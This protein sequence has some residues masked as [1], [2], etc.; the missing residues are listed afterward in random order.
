MKLFFFT[1]FGLNL[2]LTSMQEKDDSINDAIN[3]AMIKIQ[4]EIINENNN[5]NNVFTL[6]VSLQSIQFHAY[7]D[8]EIRKLASVQVTNCS[9]Y[10]RRFPKSNGLNDIRMGINDPNLKCPTC[11]KANDCS[12]H[13][14]FIELE[15]PI[16]RIGFINLTLQL[17][18]CVCWG[19]SKPKFYDSSNPYTDF[20]FPDFIKKN[21]LDIKS[22]LV[23]HKDPKDILKMVS[24]FCKKKNVCPWHTNDIKTKEEKEQAE[25][26]NLINESCGLPQCTYTKINK[27]FIKRTFFEKAVSFLEK[28]EQ[29]ILENE[30]VFP[31]DIRNIFC[32]IHEEVFQKLGFSP[33]ISHPKNFIG[34]TLLVPPPNIRPANISGDTQQRCENDITMLYQNVIR[35]NEELKCALELFHKEHNIIEDVFDSNNY[36]K[37]ILELWDKLQILSAAIINQN[38]KNVETYNGKPA[39]FQNNAPK[40]ILKDIKSRL[41]GK[42]GRLRANLSGKRVDHAARTVIGPDSTHDIFELGVPS[43]IMNTLTF[44]E[45]VCSLNIENLRNRINIG[46]HDDD[47]ALCIITKKGGILYLQSMNKESKKKISENL[48]IGDV[49]E[50]HLK[51]GDWVV[52]NRQPTLHKAS[53]MAFQCYRVEGYQFKLSLACTRA[54]NADFDGDEMNLHALQDYGAI[55]EAMSLMSVPHQIVTPQNNQVLISLVQDGL[56]GVFKLSDE[57][58]FMTKETAMQLSLQIHYDPNSEDY[59]FPPMTSK[60]GPTPFLYSQGTTNFQEKISGKQ[61]LSFLFP[62]NFTFLYEDIYISEGIFFKGQLKKKSVGTGGVLIKSMWQ[63]YG[64]WATAKFISDLQ[65]VAVTWLTYETE[66][67]SIKDCLISEEES[68]KR[69]QIITEA[70]GKTKDIQDLKNGILYDVREFLQTKILQDTRREIGSMILEKMNERQGAISTLVHCGSKGNEMNISQISGIVGQQS[71]GG[72]RIPFTLSPI[73]P[74]TLACFSPND[75]SPFSRGFICNSY[76]KGLTPSEFFYHQQAGREGVVATAVQ[77]ADAGYNQRRMIKNQESEVVAYDFTVRGS[78]NNILQYKYG[79]DGLD[80]S[81]LIRINLEKFLNMEN[82]NKRLE[83]DEHQQKAIQLMKHILNEKSKYNLHGPQINYVSMPSNLQNLLQ[84]YPKK[85]LKKEHEK[86]LWKKQKNEFEKLLLHFFVNLANIQGMPDVI[87]KKMKSFKNVSDFLQ[88][89]SCIL[90]DDI[91]FITR[92]Y[93]TIIVYQKEYME[94]HNLQSFQECLFTFL[95]EYKKGCIQPGEAAGPVGSSCIGEPSTQMTLNVF[96]HAGIAEKNVTLMGLPRFKQLIDACDSKETSNMFLKTQ[97]AAVIKNLKTENPL[98]MSIFM[99]IKLIDIIEKYEVV[100]IDE[101]KHIYDAAKNTFSEAEILGR[102]SLLNI[103]N[104]Y[105]LLDQKDQKDVKSE[106]KNNIHYNIFEEIYTSKA[107]VLFNKVLK[108][109][110]VPPV[111]MCDQLTRGFSTHAFFYTIRKDQLISKE[112][113]FQ[114]I[115]NHII[116]FLGSLAEVTHSLECDSDW[117]ILI[118]PVWFFYDKKEEKEKHEEEETN[119]KNLQGDKMAKFCEIF[120]HAIIEDCFVNGIR[121]IKRCIRQKNDFAQTDGSNMLEIMKHE[122]VDALSVNSNNVMEVYKYLGVEGAGLIMQEEFQ[123][124][125]GFDGSYVDEKHTWLLVDTM[126]HSGNI[127]PLNRFKMEEMGGSILQRASFEQTLEVFESG[128]AFGKQDF[129]SGSTERMVVGQPVR[130]GTGCFSVFSNVIETS[131]PNNQMDLQQESFD[132]DQE[133]FLNKMDIENDHKISVFQ[134]QS[135]VS[136]KKSSKGKVRNEKMVREMEKEKNKSFNLLSFSK[137]KKNNL[138]NE[139]FLM[140]VITFFKEI[141]I[142]ATQKKNARIAL[143]LKN[144][145]EKERFLFLKEKFNKNCI[146]QCTYLKVNYKNSRKNEVKSKIYHKE[147]EKDSYKKEYK[148]ILYKAFDELYCTQNKQTFCIKLENWENLNQGE[149]DDSVLVEKTSLIFEN[150]YFIENT[151]EFQLIFQQKWKGENFQSLENQ[152]D[153]V[154]SNHFEHFQIKI[155]FLCPWEIQSK[156]TVEKISELLVQSFFQCIYCL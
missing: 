22:I 72:F 93:C 144:G 96:H 47:G 123:R 28:N 49:V 55:A 17:L 156:F 126:T 26:F 152:L 153:L 15:K 25:K 119:Q 97:S 149:Q 73:G 141:C 135:N 107:F 44:P 74:R 155:E 122:N 69:T 65:R 67:I 111:K 78:S 37:E 150:A 33:K 106:K 62:K 88:N 80:P 133:D 5:N 3:D 53:I 104:C 9:T 61:V 90:T 103:M 18:K 137:E 51:N 145:I 70:L 31:D 48:E 143:Y 84:Q 60:K 29:F 20:P 117:I 30:R 85:F 19:C 54:F 79:G 40:R 42:R 146:S 81:R 16:I 109:C 45:K 98:N 82:E 114:A 147:D 13:Y 4:E 100:K 134:N 56:L 8:E 91:T 87:E 2:H 113:K 154:P 127:N 6:D 10:D 151:P 58:T 68:T 86:I 21:C 118:R 95:E 99:E 24:D 7:S 32:N 92:L 52:F 116:E 115:C 43:K 36:S 38:F 11:G 75:N 94:G 102:I 59:V 77:T 131:K 138:Q 132:K 57:K 41:C 125:L 23:K 63:T 140:P 27:I 101:S 128:A 120:M 12:N 136:R 64:P 148:E 124:V 129:L 76:L 71:V 130:V 39:L 14:G 121:G 108:L 34:K 50:R 105:C 66:C 1:I 110:K 83:Q 46:A 112:I 89:L 139:K 35:A 142:L